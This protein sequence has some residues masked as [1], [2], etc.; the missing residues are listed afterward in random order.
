MDTFISKANTL[1]HPTLKSEGDEKEKLGGQLVQVLEK[2]IEP[3]LEGAGPFF[4]G[5]ESLT[6]AEVY[7]R[8]I[9]RLRLQ[10][11][12]KKLTVAKALTAPFVLRYRAF[13]Q[14]GLIPQSVLTGLDALPNYS[15]WS[16]AIHA[17]D[18]VTFVFDAQTLVDKTAERIAKMKAEGK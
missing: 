8:A 2:E 11:T 1:L 10:T 6:L 15:K 16:K 9:Q 3:L 4:G 14:N 13:A 5:K 18:A 12:V 7:R 17:Q